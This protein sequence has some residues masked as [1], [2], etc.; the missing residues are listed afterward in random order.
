MA[1]AKNASS[2]CTRDVRNLPLER[3]RLP[4]DGR[5][6][7]QAARSRSDLL[8]RISSYANGDGTFVRDGINYSPSFE[9]LQKHIPEKSFYRLT[10]ALRDLRLLSWTREDHYDRRV[11]IIHLDQA[12]SLEPESP[13]TFEK[14]HLSDSE[15]SPVTFAVDNQ[16]HLSHSPKSPVMVTPETPVMVRDYPSCVPSLSAKREGEPSLPPAVVNQNPLLSQPCGATAAQD[17]PNE[18]G[19][20]GIIVDG[21]IKYDP[22]KLQK[23]INDTITDVVIWAKGI[24]AKHKRPDPDFNTKGMAAICEELQKI[25]KYVGEY[26]EYVTEDPSR[27]E[28]FDTHVLYNI[29]EKKIEAS[30][31][32]QL[33]NFSTRLGAT[34]F[35]DYRCAVSNKPK[36]KTTK[37]AGAAA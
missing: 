11:Y 14:N 16:N 7:K 36:R 8:L 21:E 35:A 32:F 29:L 19:A 4:G 10:N 3:F 23:A 18:D 1:T 30:D 2:K 31:N 34:L 22:A 9:T 28:V 20:V 15:K 27:L 24:C 25:A 6:W 26:W 12:G 17:E 33:K 37:P 5:K 13:V